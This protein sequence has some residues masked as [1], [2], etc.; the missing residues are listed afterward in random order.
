MHIL[1]TLIWVVVAVL[2]AILASNN[3][4]DVTLNLWGSL[5]ADIKLP[6]L[7]LVVWGL[8]FVPTALIARGRLWRVKRK[9]QLQLQLASAAAPTPSHATD[10]VSEGLA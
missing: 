8:G 6:L 7:L 3:W 5:Q 2:L 9:L 4:T 1:R 10:G